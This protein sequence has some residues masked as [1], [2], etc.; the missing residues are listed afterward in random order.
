MIKREKYIAKIRSF[1]NNDLIKIITGVRRCGKSEILKQIREEISEKNDNI[2]F[3]NFEDRM[4]T[5]SIQKWQDIVT[6]VEKNRKNGFCYVFLDEVQEIDEWQLACKTLRLRDCS[7]FIT[8]SNSKLLS[9]EFT[10]ELS[11]RYVDFRIRPFVYKEILEYAKELGRD[12]PISDYLIWGGFPK[13]LEFQGEEELRIYL[14]D[15]DK[16]IVENDIINRYKIKKSNEFRK[17]A[18]YTLISNSRIYSA[19]SIADYMKGNN[20]QCT[21]NT[22]QKWIYYLSEAYIIDQ[23]DRY[24]KKAKKFLESSHK[25]YN[26]DVALNTIR[27][28]NNR[29]DITH[30]LENVIYNELIY[31]GYKISVY[32][33]NGRE[34]D[35]LAEK[36]NYRYFIQVAYSVAEEKA[37]QREMSA[38]N[39]LNQIDK[40]ILI[41]NDDIDY[42]T[43]NVTHLKLKDFLLLNN[44]EEN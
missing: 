29:Y 41:T 26:C 40:K 34:I 7:V 5:E 44:L 8:G 15:L 14:N 28:L 42:S 16:T 38:F 32:D 27:C 4:V 18:S 24:S 21:S 9:K 2:I 36:G 12:V 19:K 13:R 20:T 6:Y 39:G 3:L 37:Y 43:S 17:V 35:F 10:K 23:A 31:M 25:L 30:N 33:N 1:Y 11:G 22:V